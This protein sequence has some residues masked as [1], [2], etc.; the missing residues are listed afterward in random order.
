VGGGPEKGS[1]LS[2]NAQNWNSK[3]EKPFI[4]QNLLPSLR[5]SLDGSLKTSEGQAD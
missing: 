4:K 3:R 2:E 5:E 1:P